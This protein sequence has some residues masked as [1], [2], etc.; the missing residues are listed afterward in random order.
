[1]PTGYWNQGQESYLPFC[2][3]Y[4]VETLCK[5]RLDLHK[6]AQ[7]E[8]FETLLKMPPSFDSRADALSSSV[9]ARFIEKRYNDAIFGCKDIKCESCGKL[10]TQAGNM[11]RHI[12]TLLQLE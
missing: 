5:F 4:P 6:K 1:M 8:N 11:R 3:S 10:F 12:K 7:R 2:F 9:A